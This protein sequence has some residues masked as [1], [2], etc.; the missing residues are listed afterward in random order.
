MA[1]LSLAAAPAPRPFAATETE[2][3]RCVAALAIVAHD[4]A[5]PDSDYGDVM[6]L[7]NRGARFAEVAGQQIVKTSGQSREAVRDRILAEVA[8]FQKAYP[9]AAVLPDATIKGCI[10]V[11]ERVAPAL[12]PPSPVHCAAL[13]SLAQGE[14]Q[15]R[16]GMSTTTSKLAVYAALL[17]GQARDSLR[18]EGK[19]ENESDM[20][21][22][23]ARDAILADTAK[24]QAAGESAEQD[25]EACFAIANPPKQPHADMSHR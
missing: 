19:T 8:A 4:Q 18:A 15:A 21:I 6:P 23:L 11:M 1:G 3:L 2:Q 17:T 24:K 12:P 13:I 25:F 9:G 5:R 7:A 10:A 20:A 16:E 14:M 22:G